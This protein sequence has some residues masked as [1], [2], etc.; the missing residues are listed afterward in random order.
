[1]KTTID[2]SQWEEAEKQSVPAVRP[3]DRET[4]FLQG[5]QADFAFRCRGQSMRPTFFDG[6]IVFIRRQ[7]AFSD[8]QIV[9]VMIDNGLTLKRLY[10]LSDGYKL[11]PDNKDFDP[12]TICGVDAERVSVY[13]IAVARA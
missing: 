12:V 1:M 3:S 4:V 11:I 8:G 7:T 10:K 5:A 6:D 9:A 2:F 13:G